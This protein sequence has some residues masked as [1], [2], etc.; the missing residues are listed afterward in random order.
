MSTTL[1][2]IGGIIVA[3]IV[4]GIIA[5]VAANSEVTEYDITDFDM[6]ARAD[7]TCYN[8]PFISHPSYVT[9]GE[10]DVVYD[11]EYGRKSLSFRFRFRVN[12][13]LIFHFMTLGEVNRAIDAGW[14]A[15]WDKNFADCLAQLEK[16]ATLPNDGGE[17]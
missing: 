14:Q 7:R 9:D 4:V 5:I 8:L 13:Q 3:T 10:T 1:L 12:G 16:A 2:I 15:Y 6:S 11:E 17:A